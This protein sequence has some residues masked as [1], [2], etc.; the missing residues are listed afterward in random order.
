[1]IKFKR[2]LSTIV[3]ASFVII[4]ALIKLESFP[5]REQFLEFFIVP[6][7]IVFASRAATTRR[8]T[9][10]LKKISNVSKGTG[11]V[12]IIGFAIYYVHGMNLSKFFTILI[13]PAA[14]G[15]LIDDA[16]NQIEESNRKNTHE[17]RR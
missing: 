16:A 12:I 15:W 7:G 6:V 1:M 10:M 2:I 17:N 3:V 11:Y 8:N 5:F 14:L 13:I 4:S 9:D